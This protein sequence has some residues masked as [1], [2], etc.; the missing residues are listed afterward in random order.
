MEALAASKL[1]NKPTDKMW[2]FGSHPNSRN[3]HHAR[4]P[5]VPNPDYEEPQYSEPLRP[6]EGDISEK[7][8]SESEGDVSGNDELDEDEKRVRESLAELPPAKTIKEIFE[9]FKGFTLKKILPAD[10][11][12]KTPANF[13]GTNQDRKKLD[14]LINPIDAELEKNIAALFGPPFEIDTICSALCDYVALTD[15][16]TLTI[17]QMKIVNQKKSA[18]KQYKPQITMFYPHLLNAMKALSVYTSKYRQVKESLPGEDYDKHAYNAWVEV[19]AYL[20]SIQSVI[21][22]AIAKHGWEDNNK[23]PKNFMD[24][25]DRRNQH[26]EVLNNLI[27]KNR[28][29]IQEID[30]AILERDNK[31]RAVSISYDGIENKKSFVL[32]EQGS[33]MAQIQQLDDP[34]QIC[35][36]NLIQIR[37]LSSI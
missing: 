26:M 1:I 24:I 32:S 25:I 30:R 7:S 11:V 33:L 5:V 37:D 14:N 35:Q 34:T 15:P 13:L 10:L 12:G 3:K 23:L 2:L 9:K 16:H 28:Q 31:L 4:Q 29:A 36:Q 18:F 20:K 6:P 17:S 27:L 8:G 19:E 21:A 22:H